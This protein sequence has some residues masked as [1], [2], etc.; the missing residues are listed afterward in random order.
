MDF[1]KAGVPFQ[2]AVVVW[3]KSVVGAALPRMVLEKARVV[4]AG[5][6]VEFDFA[7]VSLEKG[8][9]ETSECACF[10]PRHA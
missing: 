10:F 2:F 4:F 6:R 7:V 9:V 3:L 1:P 8:V 5:A